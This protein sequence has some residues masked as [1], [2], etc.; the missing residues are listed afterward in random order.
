MTDDGDSSLLAINLFVRFKRT[1]VSTRNYTSRVPR[2]YHAINTVTEYQQYGTTN[3]TS[4]APTI[5]ILE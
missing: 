2:T 5:C 1:A 4:R 3:N